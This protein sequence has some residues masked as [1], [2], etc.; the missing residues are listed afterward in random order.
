MSRKLKPPVK[1]RRGTGYPCPECGASTRVL[2]TSIGERLKT[3]PR[4]RVLR[5][6]ICLSRARHRFLTEERHR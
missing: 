6:R 2:R 3:S 1:R 5:D 4:D